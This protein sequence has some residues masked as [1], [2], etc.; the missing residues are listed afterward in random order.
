MRIAYVSTD[1]G[2]P[3]F[4][5]KGGSIHVQE[6]LRAFLSTGA[7]VAVISPRLNDEP[8]RDLASV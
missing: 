7:D 6:M 2:V 5:M 4:G 3:V 8:P 1:P